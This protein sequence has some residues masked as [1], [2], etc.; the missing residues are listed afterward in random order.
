MGRSTQNASLAVPIP[1]VAV[2]AATLARGPS[3]AS[4]G[5]GREP[6]AQQSPR[7]LIVEDDYFIALDSEATLRA[8]GFDV[9]GIAATGEQAVALALDERPA[10]VLMDI[11][12]R[13]DLD[14]I[15]AAIEIYR[16]TGIACIFASAYSG[17]N[18]RQ[19]AAPAEPL[20]WLAKPFTPRELLGAVSD[21]VA[22]AE[23][24][25]SHH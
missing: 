8:A 11:R 9:L 22:E 14:G 18:I 23:R 5:G 10:L 21:A 16:R 7:I 13:G 1:G 20:G 17:P 24:R 15:D 19:R 3:S 6:V 2:L 12:L 4:H 25:R